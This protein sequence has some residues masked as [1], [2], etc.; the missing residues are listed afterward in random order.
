MQ[1]AS[2]DMTGLI[3][4]V[5]SRQG[6]SENLEGAATRE[7]NRGQVASVDPSFRHVSEA[8]PLF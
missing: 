7:V 3:L 1:Y 5:A 6:L 4:E 8:V 2:C